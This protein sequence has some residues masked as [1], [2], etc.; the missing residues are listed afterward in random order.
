MRSTSM[1][2]HQSGR[3]IA[4]RSLPRWRPVL[5]ASALAQILF[6]VVVVVVNGEVV[7]PLIVTSAFLSIG[8]VVLGKRRRAGAAVLGIVSVAHLATSAPFLAEGLIHPESFWDFWL[9]WSTVLAAALGVVSA[10]PVWRQEDDG[11]GWARAVS[12]GV[13]TLI[14]GFG[15]VGGA[16]TRAYKSDA[17]QSGDIALAARNVEFEPATLRAD[18]GEVLIFV[19]NE[20]F[21]R[22]TF[23]ID[24]LEVDFELPG[25]K[26]ARVVFSAEPG[27]YEFYC[28]VPGHEDM[29]GEL[30]VR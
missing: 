18:R 24:A 23:S 2:M 16:A 17:A 3:I 22:H 28:A 14:V 27:T 19:D 8:L 20:D 4:T 7:P 9:G 26:A 1:D 11:S 12:F 6:N 29:R 10:A 30:V 15:V 21:F 25:R 5:V 13:A